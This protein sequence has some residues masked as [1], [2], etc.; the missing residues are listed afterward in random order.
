MGIYFDCS[1]RTWL[2]PGLE[3]YPTRRR[4]LEH[5]PVRSLWRAIRDKA[6]I[7]Q[8]AILLLTSLRRAE[9]VI[10]GLQSGADDYLV[11]PVTSGDLRQRVQRALRKRQGP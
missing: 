11:R 8:P 4:H 5:R 3:R 2:Q 6:D 7:A 1:D 10:R 9:D